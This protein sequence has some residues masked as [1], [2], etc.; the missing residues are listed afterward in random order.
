MHAINWGIQV[1]K[2]LID[3]KKKK[4]TFSEKQNLSEQKPQRRLVSLSLGIDFNLIVSHL[5]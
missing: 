5:L 4:K 2:G 3:E 1:K